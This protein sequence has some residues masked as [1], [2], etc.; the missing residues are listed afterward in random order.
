MKFKNV[1]ALGLRV[2]AMAALVVFFCGADMRAQMKQPKMVSLKGTLIDLTCASKGQAL[3]N[4]WV[5]T[6]DDQCLSLD[7]PWA[8]W[9]DQKVNPRRAL[10][11]C[12]EIAPGR[13]TP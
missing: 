13:P 2:F 11:A 12:R 8:D 5:N 9:P 4:S 6:G 7:A 1:S 3:M 10:P